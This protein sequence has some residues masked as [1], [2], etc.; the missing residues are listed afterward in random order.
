MT[1]ADDP[2]T[3]ADELLEVLGPLDAEPAP[4]GVRDRLLAAVAAE[5]RRGVE[6]LPAL[7]VFEECVRAVDDVVRSVPSAARRASVDTYPWD[8][9]ELLAHLA[10]VERHT[11]SV[12]GLEP[13]DHDP[14]RLDHLAVGRAWRTDLLRSGWEAVAHAWRAAAAATIADLR[15]GR[16]PVPGAVVHLH[17]WPLD[18]EALLVVRSFELWTHAD[19]LRRACG[20][21]MAAPSP[22]ALRAMSS[23]SVRALP[24]L[25]SVVSGGNRLGG[26]RVVL[27][28]DGGGTYDLGVAERTTTVVAD[29]VDYC[30]LV[31]RRAQHDVLRVHG[32]ASPV[33]DVVRA[34]QAIAI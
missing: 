32:D 9:T 5:P 28:G 18:L 2:R 10:A 30:R 1:T 3:P 29:V 11:R 24:L 34:A 14:D 22:A 7:D 23:T 26:V 12:L 13:D 21:P 15:A 25:A 17:Q 31:A 33:G 16:A 6:P 27:T 8:A 19:D 20:F 4:A